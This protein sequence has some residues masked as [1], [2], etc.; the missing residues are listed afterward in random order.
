MQNV[1]LEVCAKTNTGRV[2]NL[3]EDNYIVTNNVFGSTWS[4]PLDIYT[5]DSGTLVAI[6]DGMGGA[7][8]GEVA[9]K[10]AIES[11]QEYFK[12]IKQI[13][14]DN[15]ANSKILKNSVLFAHK[16][17]LNHAS[18]N[19]ETDG[20]GTTLILAWF[21]K[22]KVYV[23]WVGD[24]RCYYYRQSKG[25]SQLSKD[26]SLVQ[27]LIDN[28]KIT[29]EAA[30]NHPQSNIIL[31]SLGDKEREP[32][33]DVLV[34][35]IRNDDIILLCSDGLN[36]MLTDAQIEKILNKTYKDIHSCAETLIDEANRAGGLDNIT[37]ALIKV[38]ESDSDSNNVS[39][40]GNTEI[41]SKS[42]NSGKDKSG[43][44]I[45]A[46][47]TIIGLILLSFF[48]VYHFYNFKFINH[49]KK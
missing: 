19:K 9:S 49:K 33:P 17:I 5:N 35:T 4:A 10:I 48:L 21:L 28:K 25:L 6:A 14:S 8:A 47:I 40:M 42:Y 20:M 36:S 11:V 45:W 38:F 7:N 30:F 24:S 41:L 34:K 1:F 44:K 12:L 16:N 15:D 2:R 39:D 31:Q 37:V 29:K 32:K 27:N 13:T 46:I 18:F 22:E 26:H 43:R 3:N 23:A